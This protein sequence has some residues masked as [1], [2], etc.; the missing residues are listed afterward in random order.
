MKREK[1]II[2]YI[3]I[4]I[5]LLNGNAY[6]MKGDY[7][8]L[9]STKAKYEKYFTIKEAVQG[10]TKKEEA[11]ENKKTSK[12]NTGN[13]LSNFVYNPKV[14]MPI[15]H[16]KYLFKMTRLRKLDYFKTLAVLKHESQYN[17]YA[18]AVND[19]G[20]MQVNSQNHL[21]LSKLLK[22]ENA[23][24]D[25]YININ[26]GTYMLSDFYDHWRIS[27]VKK[28]KTK[29]SVFNKLDRYA[30]SSYNKGISGFM[31]HGEAMSYLRKVEN[32]YEHILEIYKDYLD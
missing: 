11:A 9:D 24:L 6:A 31:K 29:I 4:I 3:V 7:P 22:T 12:V 13:G 14:K 26:W 17:M 16:Q 23:P 18:I 1:K 25:P 27:G 30:M 28:L 32:E 10:A 2:I 15:E 21:W 20:Y 8:V 5:S 19:Y